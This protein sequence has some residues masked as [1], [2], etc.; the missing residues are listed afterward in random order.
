VGKFAQAFPLFRDSTL[1]D[2]WQIAWQIDAN[3]PNIYE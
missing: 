3:I 2:Q 1:I